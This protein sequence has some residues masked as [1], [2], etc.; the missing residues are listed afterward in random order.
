MC[1]Q[2]H[3]QFKMWPGT[4]P[5]HHSL[6]IEVRRQS[7]T[8]QQNE[9]ILP[10]SHPSASFG[11]QWSWRSKTGGKASYQRTTARK[12]ETRTACIKVSQH[13]I[14]MRRSP[15]KVFRAAFLAIL[16]VYVHWPWISPRAGSHRCRCRPLRCFFILRFTCLTRT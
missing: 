3:E 12:T 8:I 6:Q 14:V 5:S 15:V 4:T 16:Q 13:V 7:C 9:N 10:I 2:S 1:L 11:S